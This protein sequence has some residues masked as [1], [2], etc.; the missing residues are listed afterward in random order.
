MRPDRYFRELVDGRRRG[1]DAMILLPLLTLVSIPYGLA[2]RVRSRLYKTG[3]LPT[4]RLPKPVIAVGNISVGGTGK[5]PVTA[6][7]A[8][9]C[10][11]RGKK[12]CVISRG[13]GGS[14]EGSCRIVSDGRSVLL[15]AGEA[16][17]EPVLLAKSVPGLMVVIGSDRHAAGLYA[18]ERLAPDIF[19]L[20]DG[21]Q[22][23]RL[24]RDLNVLLLDCQ[25]PFGNGKVLPAGLLREPCSAA[26]R[27]DLVIYTR[28]GAH[29][30][31]GH[32]PG[33]P[34]CRA[35]HELIGVVSPDGGAMQP[36]SNLF[37]L[38]GVAFAGIADPAVFFTMLD[39]AGLNIAARVSLP[40][41]C[42]YGII[43]INEILATSASVASDYLITTEKDLVKLSAHMEQLGR[44]YAAILEVEIAD[45]E[46]LTDKL[47]KFL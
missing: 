46:H 33:I 4:R 18:L 39:E 11:D 2:M 44:V 10:L 41:H 20:D 30:P 7:I 12:V 31:Y 1:L 24:H 28:C 26:K 37:H 35:S 14:L 40:D 15:S 8:R 29:I 38:R 36:L 42:R 17:D 27:A 16:G 23:I 32:F 13:Y 9:Y 34:F 3:I 5:T 6:L 45:K 21:Y 43:E 22:H 47:Q 25:R 19:I